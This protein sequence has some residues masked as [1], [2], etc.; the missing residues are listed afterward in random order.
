MFLSHNNKLTTCPPGALP[1]CDVDLPTL[2]IPTFRRTGTHLL[3]DIILNNFPQYK[4]KPLF[5]DLDQWVKSGKKI[6]EIP[7][8]I[9]CLI[10]THIPNSLSN[11]YMTDEDQEDLI[12]FCRAPEVKIISTHREK[13]QVLNSLL[14]SFSFK[15][16]SQELDQ[17]L[18]TFNE[19]WGGFLSL[20]VP[21]NRLS[22]PNKTPDIV[23]KISEYIQI[24][25]T[26]KTRPIFNK[27]AKF[28][29]YFWKI[30]TRLLGR[31]SLIVNTT[32]GF[33]K[34]K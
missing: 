3:I 16:S 13:Q 8:D 26:K 12:N 15:I 31:K 17:Q 6:S 20:A 24:S 27:S 28:K 7:T 9:G 19:F 22:D 18:I 34:S 2:V 1:T 11:E 33:S 29:V 23:K 14:K 30:M 4:Q 25:S 5:I 21:F 32:I 10:K